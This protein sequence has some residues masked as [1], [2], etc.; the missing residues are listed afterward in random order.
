MLYYA[1]HVLPLLTWWFCLRQI[2]LLKT[3]RIRPRYF[4]WIALLIA[5]ME[6]L[7]AGMIHMEY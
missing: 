6:L 2:S 5:G 1:Y 7:V 4:I 3:I